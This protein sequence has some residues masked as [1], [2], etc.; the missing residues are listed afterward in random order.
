MIKLPI[1][2]TNCRGTFQL[3]R[4]RR[5]FNLERVQCRLLRFRHHNHPPF[6]KPAVQKYNP[7]DRQHYGLYT[8]T[9][10]PPPLECPAADQ[11]STLPHGRVFS[12]PG[13]FSKIVLLRHAMMPSKSPIPIPYVHQ[14]RHSS[15]SL[16]SGNSE[17]GMMA[18]WEI[19]RFRHGCG[20]FFMSS[21][22]MMSILYGG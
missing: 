3:L 4:T 8:R 21:A 16:R 1:A 17:N 14:Y 22:W 5:F 6:T 7:T 12:T 10:L 9:Y 15:E 2:T 18:C 20:N 19:A 13:T 11:V